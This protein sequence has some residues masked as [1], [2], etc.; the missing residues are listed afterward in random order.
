MFGIKNKGYK[1]VSCFCNS[2]LKTTYLIPDF[3]R[4]LDDKHVQKIYYGILE[5]KDN[6]F[7]IVGTPIIAVCNHK[8]YIIDGQHRIAAL[9]ILCSGDHHIPF[10]Y[11]YELMSEDKCFNSYKL[12]TSYKPHSEI[13]KNAENSKQAIFYKEAEKWIESE[14]KLKGFKFGTNRPNIR[15]KELI[16]SFALRSDYDV[17]NFIQLY[18]NVNE[19]ME[20]D[21]KNG[22]SIHPKSN[23]KPSDLMEIKAKKTRCYF[24][25]I[26]AKNYDNAIS[27]YLR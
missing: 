22:I 25:L 12:L 6:I 7:I 26:E 4:E 17:K 18:T 10:K 19:N 5:N 23:K 27:Y 3:Q 20:E 24:A 16:D 14:S 8:K 15:K 13:G 9:R 2:D 21:F 11:Q 1:D